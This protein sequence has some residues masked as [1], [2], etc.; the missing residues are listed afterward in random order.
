MPFYVRKNVT[1]GSPRTGVS[2]EALE[3]IR[4]RNTLDTELYKFGRRLFDEH[5]R[6]EGPLFG[7]EVTLFQT[8]NRTA[9]AY[10]SGGDWARRIT[11]KG[12]TG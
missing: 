3:I 6:R 9:R 7:T 8:L 5:V 2:S 11:S 12:E 1:K 4:A 10:R